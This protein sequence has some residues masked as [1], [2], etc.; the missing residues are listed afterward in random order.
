MGYFLEL[1]L[2]VVGLLALWAGFVLGRA[3]WSSMYGERVT[4]AQ[5]RLRQLEQE[6]GGVE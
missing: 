4:Q 2:L 5:D 1:V 6:R 3:L